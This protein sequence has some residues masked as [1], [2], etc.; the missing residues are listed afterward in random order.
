[1]PL[2]STHMFQ[3]SW[4][5]CGKLNSLRLYSAWSLV[6]RCFQLWLVPQISD[7]RG[8][9]FGIKHIWE[10]EITWYWETIN[11]FCRW[12]LPWDVQPVRG[13]LCLPALLLPFLPVPTTSFAWQ[14]SQRATSTCVAP[15]VACPLVSELLLTW[16]CAHTSPTPPQS[17]PWF[18]SHW[19]QILHSS[20][21]H[22]HLMLSNEAFCV[23]VGVK[24]LQSFLSFPSNPV[25]HIAFTFYP[26]L[27]ASTQPFPFSPCLP[28]KLSEG[29][30][31]SLC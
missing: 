9:P 6:Q 23:F 7:P 26:D 10:V 16:P 21:S 11:S 27:P 17:S 18:P 20:S 29:N 25:F 30:Q 3:K 31:V 13:T 19:S 12:A 5:I 8:D 2:D 14:P 4:E 28:W 24:L 1:M 15:T 22:S